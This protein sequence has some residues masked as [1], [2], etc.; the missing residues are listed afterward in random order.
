[1]Q[2]KGGSKTYMDFAGNM[3][4]YERF[5]KTLKEKGI[6]QYNLVTDYNI[7]KSLLQRLRNNEGISTHS[8]DM[9]CSILDCRV[10]DI[11]EFVKDYESPSENNKK[12]E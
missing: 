8:L 7:S 2:V 3:I 5:W 9:L 1:M 10:E 4:K 11:I 12:D 6:S